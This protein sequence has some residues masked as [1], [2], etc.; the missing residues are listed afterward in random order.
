MT[1]PNGNELQVDTAALQKFATNLRTEAT[2]VT[3]LGAG[4]GFNFA[5]GAL[6]GTD[7]GTVVTSATDTL[8]NC[9]QRINERLGTVADNMQNAAGKFELAEAEFADKLKTIGLEVK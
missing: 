1:G 7:F 4:A 2:D 6:P 3:S 9:L 5:S 8:N